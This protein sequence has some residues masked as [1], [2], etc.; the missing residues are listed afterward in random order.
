VLRSSPIERRNYAPNELHEADRAILLVQWSLACWVGIQ[1][2]NSEGKHVSIESSL[3][4]IAP[5]TAVGRLNYNEYQI[6]AH[7]SPD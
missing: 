3:F 1:Q 6:I 7:T 5:Y 4:E 2:P